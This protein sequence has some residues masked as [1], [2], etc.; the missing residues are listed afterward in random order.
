MALIQAIDLRKTY[1][2]PGEPVQV[3]RGVDLEV[4]RGDM[5]TIV[6]E[7]GVGKTTLLYLLGAMERCTSGD[8]LFEGENLARMKDARM[9]RFRNLNIGFVFQFH[10]LI[11]EFTALENTA[12]PALLAGM[13]HKKALDRGM[14]LFHQFGI[15]AR[16][17]HKPGELSGGEQQ[18]VAVARALVMDP[19]VVLA[20]EPTGNL[21]HITGMKLMDLFEKLNHENGVTF[22]IV[23]H[24]ERFAQL[25]NRC[26]RLVDGKAIKVK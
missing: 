1:P 10:H 3:L 5:V 11:Q 23:T 15:E 16:A 12:M 19:K 6:G 8:L 21:D 26:I 24:N 25:G 14:E 13:S 17:L 4:E 22:I 9:D 18:R 7:S 2:G 20:D